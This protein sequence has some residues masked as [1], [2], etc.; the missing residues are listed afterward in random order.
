LKI[1]IS[2]KYYRFWLLAWLGLGVASC[3]SDKSILSHA[4]NNVAAR[5]N[6]F[7]LAR[8]KLWA[9]EATLY[10]GRSDDYNR[11]LPLYPTLDSGTVR[12]TRPDLNDIIKKASLPIQH[13]A[14]SDWTD[15]AYLLVGWSRFY[16][17][18]FDDAILTFK[19]VNSTSRDPFAKQEALIGLMRA[20]LVTKQLDNAK[21]VSDLLDKEVGLPK[22]ARELFLAR[23]DY[24]LQTE[25][26]KLAIAQLEKAVP[27]IPAK[28]ERSRT[29]FIL[30]Q[31]YQA[32]GQDKEATAQLDN[33]LKHNPPY[34]LDFQSK[35][36]LGQVSDLDKQSKERLDKYFAALLKD[37]KNKE[38]RDKIYYEMGRLAYRQQKYSDALA[39]LRT[40]ARQ[41]TTSKSQKGYT[42]LLAGRIYYENLQ[43]YRLAA[44]YYDSTTQAMPKDNPLF[45][46]TK[47][48]ADILK[49][50]AKQ[51]TIVE[52][53]D[54][55]QALAKLP[56]AEL[57]KR[58]NTYAAA[59]LEAK[60]QAEA[61]LM[62]AQKA[63]A[64]KQQADASR[65]SGTPSALSGNQRDISNPNAFDA[66]TAVASG[67][68]WYFDN[69]TSLG[70]A[71]AD[72]LRLWGDRK[73]QDNWRTTNTPSS[74]PNAPQNGGVPVSIT[75]NDQTR[76][77][78]GVTGASPGGAAAPADPLAEQNALVAR[79][80]QDLP[81]TPTKLQT[82]DQQ[83][84]AAMYELGGIYKELLKERQRGYET[85]AG[86]V[87]RY[88][89][90]AHAPDADY[91]LY[92]YYKDLPDPAK[93]AQ[94]AAA[95]QREFPTSTYAR[96]IS[97]P[98]Y[99][100]HERALHNAVAARLD[101]AFALYKDQYFTRSKAVVAR[102]EKQYP[103]SD[104][105]DR[106]AYLKL[107]LAI[108]T[109]PPVAVKASVNQF[110][111]DYP[112]SPLVPQALALA[113]AYQKAEA[114]QLAGALASTEK[115]LISSQFRPGEVENRMRIA[116]AEDETPA[117]PLAKP[118]ESVP[119]ARTA[120]TA[121]PK[122]GTLQPG[123]PAGASLP[124]AKDATD[125]P[126]AAPTTSAAGKSGAAGALPVAVPSGSAPAAAPTATPAAP[127]APAV[128]YATQ[129][130]AA[131]AIVLVYPKGS[132]PTADLASQLTTYNGKFFRANNLTVQ[133][134]QPLGT[135]QEMVVVRSL[136]GSKVAQ[137]YATKLRGPQSPLARLRGQ[138]YQ[139]I[140]ISLA[141]LTL[142][143][144][145]GGDLAGYQQFYQKVYQ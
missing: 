27:L 90:G 144:E 140:V 86:Q 30:A 15:D 96:L 75:G 48:R 93:A 31:L 77:N 55:L 111:K 84:E 89:R 127:A 69:A 2:L 38:Y 88:P 42:Y 118:A 26:P 117:L 34:E 52:T 29:R 132:A 126:A 121:S 83:V 125:A 18:E 6:G 68:G 64:Q 95:L 10:K 12:A 145:T 56:D 43:K 115:P 107:L 49:E 60:R 92:L 85:Y 58:L 47:E 128:A 116:Y 14:G 65:I 130:S 112:D 94:Y 11:V 100:E 32:Q 33:I 28:N 4:L 53:Q 137:S 134:A 79:Y 9:T 139:A 16:K 113:G 119:P 21:A 108:R 106:V 78:G 71:R 135:D 3:A 59:E 13:R 51:Y 82:S 99:R 142:L 39:L 102:L 123:P 124:P 91:L 54:S 129:L 138:G 57:D 62:A 25:E 122:E 133:P 104:L 114:G 98:L 72:F 70:T 101:S 120:P 7:F 87:T 76:V 74:S 97:D 20:F 50:F 40:S 105:T 66:T 81:T 136:P 19:Y 110:A 5:D 103:K 46:T 109:Q 61:K 35:L 36:L 37:P 63:L 80:R 143:Q 23:A 22:D 44:A 1:A 141:N 73:L 45:A 17:M 41:P 8:E 67:A 131:H 24:Y